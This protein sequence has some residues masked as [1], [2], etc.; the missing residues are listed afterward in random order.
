MRIT[1]AIDPL[2]GRFV[3][4]V[5]AKTLARHA[6]AHSTHEGWRLFHNTAA[7]CPDAEH[8]PQQLRWC[9]TRSVPAAN[10]GSSFLSRARYD[11]RYW[12]IVL[13][14]IAAETRCG[15]EEARRYISIKAIDLWS[16]SWTGGRSTRSAAEIPRRHGGLGCMH[17][18][19]T[20]LPDMGS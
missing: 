18:R 3:E 16:S 6:S 8:Q 1:D 20:W 7:R 15:S 4:G 5:A 2:F 12:K 10:S 9:R 11:H 13:G 14:S 19:E 17:H